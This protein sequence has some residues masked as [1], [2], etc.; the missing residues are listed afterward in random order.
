MSI[1]KTLSFLLGVGLLVATLGGCE[2]EGPMERTGKK[3]DEAVE[4]LGEAVKKEGPVE[5]AGKKV[6]K[7][8]EDASE[9]IKDATK[10]TRQ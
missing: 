7:A 3:M 2:R 6:D 10:D 5:Q 4:N 1:Y 8:I 9:R